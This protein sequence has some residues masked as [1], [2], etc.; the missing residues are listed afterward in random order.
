MTAQDQI[1][2]ALI[3][4][5]IIYSISANQ[6]QEYN[7]N[8]FVIKVR[9][10]DCKIQDIFL[11]NYNIY[12]YI[13]THSLQ[14][15][16]AN[17]IYANVAEDKYENN[18]KQKCAY[19]KGIETHLLGRDGFVQLI[20]RLA[21]PSLRRCSSLSCFQSIFESKFLHSPASA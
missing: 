19:V 12:N 13:K 1:W 21:D 9:T 20:I 4:Y 2:S 10:I 8:I 15:E 14:N 11:P 18:N 17:K 6:K 7:L 5:V 16:N 3:E